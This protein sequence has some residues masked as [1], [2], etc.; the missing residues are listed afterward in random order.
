M[1]RNLVDQISVLIKLRNEHAE[2]AKRFAERAEFFDGLLKEIDRVDL[3]ELMREAEV[4]ELTAADGTRL[5]LKEKVKASIPEH[6]REA[7]HAWLIEQ[8]FGGLIKTEVAVSFSAGQEAEAAELAARL[9]PE[10]GEEVSLQQGVHAATLNAFVAEQM[11]QGR[12]L[13][14]E[15]FNVFTFSEV[16]IRQPR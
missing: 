2:N 16:Q 14:N 9:A 15:L 5:K 13:P 10:Y 11:E 8:G 6:K 12:P 3:P 7:A 4:K 1:K